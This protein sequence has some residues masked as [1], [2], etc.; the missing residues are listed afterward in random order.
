MSDEDL[1][2]AFILPMGTYNFAVHDFQMRTSKANNPM[3]ELQIR[4]IDG[5]VTHTIFDYLVNTL[6]S[7]YKIKNFC[8]AVGKEDEYNAGHLN[9]DRSWLG[10]RGQCKIGIQAGNPKPDGSGNYSDKNVILDYIRVENAEI[11]PLN[12]EEG[13]IILKAAGSAEFN[14]EIPF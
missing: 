1:N 7:Q 10:M 9:P 11:L 6:K 4:I 13:L 14:D 5:N 8:Y 3:I 12:K 2:R